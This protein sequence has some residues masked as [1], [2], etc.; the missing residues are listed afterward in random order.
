MSTPLPL[1][2]APYISP[3]TLQTAPTGIDLPGWSTIG[4][5]T[6]DP[7]PAQNINEMWMMCARATSR[8]DGYVNQILRAT[9]D[10]ELIHGPNYRTTVGPASGGR[11]PTPY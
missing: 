5:M 10:V 9:A 2:L 11:Y 3:L 1:G 4:E 6:A 7:S 8:V